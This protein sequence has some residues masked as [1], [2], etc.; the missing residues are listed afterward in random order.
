MTELP[1]VIIDVQRG[2][3][4]TGLPTKTEQADLLQCM[5]G[6]N[7]ESPVAIVAPATPGDC[8][9]M[10]IEAV[11]IATKYMVPTFYLSDGYLANGSEP[12][13]IPA[14]E[15]LPKMEINFRT[16]A[17]GFFPYSRDDETLARPWAIPGTP[18]LEHRIGGIE[19]QH[20]TGNVNYDPDNHD[21]MCRLRAEKVERIANDIPPLEV[22]GEPKGKVLVL[23]WGGTH[24][25]ITTAVEQLQEQGQSVSSAHL[26]YLNPFPKN[27]GEVFEG[28]ET[29][30]IPELNLGQL[31]LLVRAKFLVDAV[32]FTQVKGKPFKVSSLVNKIKEYL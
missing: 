6:R 14:I 3:P 16:D 28:F 25:A 9:T 26:R 1:V 5:Y 21:F 10:A 15:S 29:V 19:K 13:E 18:G 24:G 32:S 7:G 23:G 12:W 20:I 8:F 27:L 4:S 11:R 22:F 31:S 30:I 2:G 17:E